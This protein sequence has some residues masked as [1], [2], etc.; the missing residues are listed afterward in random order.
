MPNDQTPRLTSAD[1]QRKYL[2]GDLI[3][4]GDGPAW[5]D[6]LVEIYS[7]RLEEKCMLV[8]A[9]AEPQIVWQISGNVMCE[10]R[11]LGGQWSSH[12]S[13]P[14]D[15]FL[16]ASPTPYELRWKAVT[17]EPS[18]VMHVFIGLP[19]LARVTQEL[20][21]PDSDLPVLK[22]VH[23]VHDA[24]LNVLLE[25]LRTELTERSPASEIFVQGVAQTLA[26][27]L[28][29]NY[30]DESVTRPHHSNVLPAFR[31]RKVEELM[32]GALEEGFHV[33]ALAEAVGLSEGH[34]SRLFKR[35]AGVSPSKYFIGLRMTKAQQLLRE[36]K[37]SIIDIGLEVGYS[38][39]SHFS[40]VFRKEV[41]QTPQDYRQV[42]H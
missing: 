36:T 22:E 23:G 10:E 41:G 39:P 38:S 40:Q 21:G 20:L 5:K 8:P 28:I 31:F 33:G 11:D 3:H 17:R 9:V 35:T 1:A 34:F 30:R 6:I 26:V 15:V 42:E 12:Q 2:P 25:Q 32:K 4:L 7:R 16:T 24:M 14:G 27:H 19:L 13:K 18:V 29:R 37:R